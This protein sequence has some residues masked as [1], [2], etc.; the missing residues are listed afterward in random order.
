M[1]MSDPQLRSAIEA[2][3][4]AAE[5]PL[6]TVTIAGAVQAP[7]ADVQAEIELLIEEL[8]NHSNG[9]GRGYEI[10][11]VGGGWRVYISERHDWGLE[12]LL[13]SEAPSKLSQAA[14]ETLAI[15]AYK[16]PVS[17]GQIAQIRGVSVDSSIKTLQSRGL[18]EHRQTDPDTGAALFETTQ[19]TLELLAINSLSELPKISPM[20]PDAENI[21]D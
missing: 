1:S 5:T 15:V 16:Q 19:Y 14:L 2:I 10:R 9:V 13:S 21:N 6:P 3:L 17:R 12:K 7:I 20:L 4:I 11:E 18:I 8:S